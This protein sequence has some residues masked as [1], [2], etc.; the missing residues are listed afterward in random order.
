MKDVRISPGQAAL[1]LF[2]LI[3]PRYLLLVPS[4]VAEMAEQD[5]WVANFMGGFNGVAVVLLLLAVASLAPGKD[6][7]EAAEEGLGRAGG[8]LLGTLLLAVLLFMTHTTLRTSTA[9]IKETFLR[10]TPLWA[11]M[12]L[13]VTQGIAGA[14]YGTEPVARVGGLTVALLFAGLLPSTVLLL[15]QFDPRLLF[16]VFARGPLPALRGAPISAFP[17][18]EAVA[19]GMLLPALG[20]TRRSGPLLAGL[21]ATWAV[22]G[23]LLAVTQGML[24]WYNLSRIPF[25]FLEGLR[26]VRVP[27]LLERIEVAVATIWVLVSFAKIAL[28]FL[29]QA[30]AAACILGLGDHR[31]LIPLL[32]ALTAVI[33][34]NLPSQRT[35]YGRV[36]LWGSI[37]STP[38]QTL[39]PALVVLAFLWRRRH[40]SGSER[41]GRTPGSPGRRHASSTRAGRSRP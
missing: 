18:G 23:S 16:P 33:S 26:V 38:I 2:V 34:L 7:I 9:F 19:L 29:V 21:L 3:W 41:S 35:V 30:R 6:L 1:L 27:P 15:G 5:A 8:R 14:F 12:A 36:L 40:V 13:L 37:V 28:L 10:V 22:A 39:V 31:P 24:G 4:L 11:N 20:G 17:F 32:A 25:S